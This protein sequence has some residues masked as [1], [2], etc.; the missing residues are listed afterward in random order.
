MTIW[1]VAILSLATGVVAGVFFAGRINV[2][3][4]RIQELEAQI[5]AMKDQ[6]T[7]Y[8]DSVSDHFNLTAELVQHMTES[9]KDV[10]QHLA[11]GAQDLCSN[12]VA[13]K[14]LPADTETV[15]NS[16]MSDDSS[17]SPPR[18]YAAKQ[19]PTQKGALAEDF[20]LDK[21]KS[22]G[23]SPQPALQESNSMAAEEE[24]TLEVV[25]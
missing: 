16:E 4:S 3:T 7:D 9:Y 12:E 1:L 15:L 14:L 10:Y 20:G 17:L 24:R 8:R 21:T 6:H 19:D 22:M 5:R 23:R 13:S 2:N 18:D 11:I 25:K